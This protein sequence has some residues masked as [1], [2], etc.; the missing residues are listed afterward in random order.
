[1]EK[2]AANSDNSISD[3][4]NCLLVNL[5]LYLFNSFYALILLIKGNKMSYEVESG[6]VPK[7]LL[8]NS[9]NLRAYH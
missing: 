5:Y 6:I 1:M 8:N 3:D 9:K 4:W 7:W 2:A